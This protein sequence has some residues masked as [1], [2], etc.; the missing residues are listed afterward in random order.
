MF[1]KE[2]I[3]LHRGQVV[4]EAENHDK[5][6]D[7]YW[8]DTLQCPTLEEYRQMISES[9]SRAVDSLAETGGLMRL[10]IGLMQAFSENKTDFSSLVVCFVKRVHQRTRLACCTRSET[11]M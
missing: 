7:I 9:G 2:L 6:K 8:R 11:T 3:S 1:I 10:S 4:E 5:G